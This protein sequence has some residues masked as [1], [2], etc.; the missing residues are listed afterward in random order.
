MLAEVTKQRRLRRRKVMFALAASFVLLAGAGAGVQALVSSL[1]ARPGSVIASVPWRTVSA[2][3]AA[4]GVHAT[5]KFHPQQWGTV[6][7]VWVSGVG[8]GIRCQLWVTDSA[9]RQVPAGSWQVPYDGE[10]DWYPGSTSVPATGIRSFDITE[11]GKT[12]VI[13]P[14]PA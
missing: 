8:Q 11:H 2:R 12:L 10:A 7:D 14:V 5:V 1:T 9:G 4:T 13:V 3:D 6:M